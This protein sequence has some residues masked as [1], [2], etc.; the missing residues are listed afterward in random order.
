MRRC[1][2]FLALL[3]ACATSKPAEEIDRL[4][5]IHRQRFEAMVRQDF[6]ALDRLIAEDVVY[7]HSD[8]LVETKQEFIKKIHGGEMRYRSIDAPD[9]VI[10]IYGDAGV[11]TGQGKFAVTRGGADR[12]IE[13]RYTA[14]YRRMGRVWQLVSW[15]STR[16]S[17]P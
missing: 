12:D 16:L 17:Q 4:R 14:V 8:A 11:V 3:A 5:D 10:R 13:L 1:V 15:Q 9:P 7:V 2:L 6:M